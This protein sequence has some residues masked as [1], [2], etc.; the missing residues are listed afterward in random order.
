[1]TLGSKIKGARATENNR[2]LHQIN[3]ASLMVNQI[4][5]IHNSKI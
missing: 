3:G 4:S 5:L 1:M 2:N